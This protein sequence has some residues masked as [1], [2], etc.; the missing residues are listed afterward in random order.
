MRSDY[1]RMK[2]L[3]LHFRRIVI[4][5]ALISS[6]AFPQQTTI[7]RIEQMP[8]MPAPYLMRNWK[9]V[10]RGYDSLV[11]NFNLSGEYLPLVWLNTSPVNYP[12]HNS[13]GLNTVVGTTSPS[14][15]EAINCLPAVIS[16]TLVGV[17]KSNQNGHNW[18]LMCEEWFNK[19]PSQNVYK[20]HSVDDTGD[21][22]WYETMPNVFFYQLQYFYPGTGDFNYQ[23][24]T[25]A[26]RWLQALLAMGASG[27]PWQIP[28]MNH[29]GW[30]LQ[31]MTPEDQSVHEPE[32]AGAIALLLYNAYM[33]TRNDTYR[34]G[35]EW[36]M[37]F[38]NQYATDPSY[39]LQLSYGTYL[40]ARMNADLG[41][42]YDVEKMVNWCFNVGPLR[43][44]GAIVGN[45]GGYDC[46]GLIGE[47][48]GVNDYA[49]SMNTFEQIG[50]LVPMVRY[51]SRFARAI[52][53]WVLNAANAGRLFYPNYLPLNN[54]DSSYRWAQRYDPNSTIAHEAIRQS[55]GMNSPFATGDAITGSW[56]L[57]T[58]T[59]YSSSH[60]GILGGIIDT[61]DVPMIL[62]LDV[63]KTDYY[64]SSA[65]PTYLYFNPYDSIKVVTID[66]GSGQHDVYDAAAHQFE[67]T[68]ITGQTSLSIPANS[69]LLAVITPSGGTMTYDLEKTLVNGV[70]IDYH[71]GRSVANYPPRIKSLMATAS[72]VL[73]GDTV[74]LFCTAVDRDKDTLR[75]SWEN[76]R[77]TIL[78]TGPQVRWV[79]PITQEVDTVTCIVSDGHG[80]QDTARILL[81]VVASVNS[82][83]VINRL[84]ALPRKIDLGAASHITCYATDPDGDTL[85]VQ[86]SSSAGSITGTDTTIAWTAPES[87]G[88]YYVS[89][90]VSDGHGG[91]AADSIGLEVRDLS[92]HQSGQLVASFPFDGN[93]HD[94]SGFN[95]NGSVYGAVPALDRFGHLN[96]AY[97]F[98]GATSYVDVPNSSSLNFRQSI[99]VSFWMYIGAFYNR[100]QYPISHGNWQNRWKV[101]ISNNHL[102]WTVKTSAGIKD[103]D[104]ETELKLN[105]WYNVIVTYDGSDFEVWLNGYLDAFSSWSGSI[106]TTSIDLTIGQ[107]LPNDQNYN[108]RGI[109]DDIGIYNYALSPQQIDTLA[110]FTSVEDH[111]RPA[112]P[113]RYFLD[114]NYP[115][116]FNPSTRIDYGLPERGYVKL[117][118]Y[119][120]LGREIVTLVDG[121]QDAGFKSV[122]WSPGEFPSGIYFCRLW[123]PS[124]Q[125]TRKLVV[126]R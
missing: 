30:Y 51:D 77:G 101:S 91:V 106:L 31:T 64:H 122:R 12:N 18:P 90:R 21:D 27:T 74:G 99:T 44:W 17:D 126:L 16:A 119:D 9:Q 69:A 85:S 32:A 103:L 117:Q 41:T 82:P 94:T 28:N 100:E 98:D 24:T 56:G 89:C 93:A 111:S 65:Y 115:N 75:Y 53:K 62:R 47:V 22:W 66:V 81:N 6:T 37:E 109:L 107:D 121:F 3:M 92:Q 114:Q 13:F 58:L 73:H 43:S 86:W 72:T 108:F 45:W 10:A 11:F 70:V 88:N 113:V 5:T 40:A 48:N 49:F 78:D 34:I 2:T 80:A 59:L 55:N 46:S 123:T 60:A 52:G 38:L 4:F 112:M 42:T 125:Q 35:A 104:S 29:R 76:P 57:T 39:E 15:A 116:P 95:N 71:S 63:L 68:G 79:A 84:V 67:L 97:S 50:A 23:V 102:R 26:D 61:T 54:Q 105:T 7:P 120:I 36:A 118:I 19:R 33:V 1:D 124:F 110:G 14:S 96:G 87:A 8:S 83:P 25:V 20:N